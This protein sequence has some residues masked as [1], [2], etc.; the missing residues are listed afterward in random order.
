MI[1]GSSISARPPLFLAA[2]LTG[3]SIWIA[4]PLQHHDLQIFCHL[5]LPITREL[6]YYYC[7]PATTTG[8]FQVQQHSPCT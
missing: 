6:I 8:I 5:H 1:H 3:L 7:K 4:Q 2:L